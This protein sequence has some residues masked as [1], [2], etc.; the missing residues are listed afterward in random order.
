MSKRSKHSEP[1]PAV[2]PDAGQFLLVTLIDHLETCSEDDC[3]QDTRI[4]I[5][6]EDGVDALP[7]CSAHA[8][9]VFAD[10]MVGA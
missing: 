10:W 7:Y 2:A 9:V 1:D 8:H 4:E 5:S 3:T 6:T